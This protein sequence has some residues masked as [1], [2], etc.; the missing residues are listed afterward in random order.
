MDFDAVLTL[1]ITQNGQETEYP[2][3]IDQ[4]PAKLKHMGSVVVADAAADKLIDFSD[5]IVS[6]EELWVMSDNKVSIK[7]NDSAN[8]ALPASKKLI[9]SESTGITKIYVSNA[10]GND[11]TMDIFA[12]G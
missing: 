10:S 7:L 12:A 5:L 2:Y 3:T 1:T 11:A 9:L 6:V 4:A 8:D